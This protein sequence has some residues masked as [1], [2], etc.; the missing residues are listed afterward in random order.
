[1]PIAAGLSS[2]ALSTSMSVHPLVR[3]AAD[4][5]QAFLTEKRTVGPPESL[6]AVLPQAARPGGVFVCL[7][8][9]GQLRGCIG[10]VEPIQPSLALEIIHNAIGAAT[11]DS[12]FSPVQAWEAELL[13]ITIDV[14]GPSEPVEGPASLDPLNFGVIVRAGAR[15]GVLLPDIEGITSATEQVT[16]ARE[17][18]GVGHDELIELYRFTVTRYR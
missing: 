7:K 1:M 13:Q 3:L 10:S 14:L 11:R 5:I 12:R 4:A 8:L 9:E 2:S 15:Q 17:K 6:F 16:I 18:A